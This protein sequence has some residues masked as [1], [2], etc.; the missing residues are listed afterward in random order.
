LFYYNI[1]AFHPLPLK[2]RGFHGTV[3]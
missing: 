3:S 1:K 2:R